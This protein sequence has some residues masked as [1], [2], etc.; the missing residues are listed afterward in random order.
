MSIGH[1][2]TKISNPN[3]LAIQES[4]SKMATR[5]NK[6]VPGYEIL[7]APTIEGNRVVTTIKV[8]GAGDYLPQY[9]GN[10]DIINCAAIS[11]AELIAKSNRS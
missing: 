9:A 1:I 6:Y 7:V 3:I 4:V 11:M 2:N 10:L 8:R 5:I